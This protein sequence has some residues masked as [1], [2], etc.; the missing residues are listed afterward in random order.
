MNRASLVALTALGLASGCQ[1]LAGR[2]DSARDDGGA[3]AGGAGAGGAGASGGG[4]AGVTGGGGAGASGGAGAGG[5]GAG[6]G[7]A[8]M[9]GGGGAGMAGAGTG[10]TAV[11][12]SW[13]RGF[14]NAT[15]PILPDSLDDVHG[16][17]VDDRGFVIAAGGHM[18]GVDLG[19]GTTEWDPSLGP[20]LGVFEPSRGLS[21]GHWSGGGSGTEEIYAV[22]VDAA[23]DIYGA[24]STSSEADFHFAGETVAQM[25]GMRQPFV[26]KIKR[27]DGSLAWLKM[28]QAAGT[29]STFAITVDRP[30]NRVIAVGDLNG[31]ATLDGMSVGSGN[32]EVM[33]LA[34][35]AQTGAKVSLAKLPANGVSEA[36]AVT[37]IGGDVLVGGRFMSSLGGFMSRGGYD[38]FVARLS[39]ADHSPLWFQY[40]GGSGDDGVTAVAASADGATAFAVGKL[41]SSAQTRDLVMIPGFG[42]SDGF[43][44]RLDGGSGA[45]SYGWAIGGAQEDGATGVALGPTDELYVAGYYEGDL[46]YDDLVGDP[47]QGGRDV[48]IL[49]AALSGNPATLRRYG[50]SSMEGGLFAPPNEHRDV[51]IAAHPAGGLVLAGTYEGA[52]AFP[53]TAALP[54]TSG[55][56]FFVALLLTL[57]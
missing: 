29:A 6:G 21:N 32:A 51:R 48:F 42:R 14:G 41:V 43:V 55:L 37:M 34:L 45:T 19:G 20:W 56:D 38:G 16:L 24:G 7:G 11:A 15:P 54:Y 57:P 39:G 27:A 35:D 53:A 30:R 4:G 26:F 25:D 9:A 31:P 23:G 50:G 28:L 22:A 52:F 36:R 10:G 47:A 13:T 2:S 17:C 46:R 8:G 1:L 49:E 3:G 40:V 18:G 44:V 33:V 5:A 12:Q